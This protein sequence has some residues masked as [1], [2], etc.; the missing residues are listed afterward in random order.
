ME[1]SK[2]ILCLNIHK[3]SLWSNTLSSLKIK[4]I[5]LNIFTQISIV[6][7][8]F[9]KIILVLILSTYFKTISP[10]KV[11]QLALLYTRSFIFT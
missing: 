1:F 5:I 10:I 4:K 2:V 6:L 7:F 3:K 8:I 11:L 9:S